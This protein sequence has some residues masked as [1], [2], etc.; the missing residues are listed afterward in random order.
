MIS[1]EVQTDFEIQAVNGV[2]RKRPISV[3]H[4]DFKSKGFVVC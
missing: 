2:V 4:D 3:K 1:V